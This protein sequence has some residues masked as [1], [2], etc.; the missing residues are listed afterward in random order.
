[1]LFKSSE[2]GY[3]IGPNEPG[4]P[5]GAE[6][7]ALYI[8]VGRSGVFTKQ[9]GRPGSTE[10]LAVASALERFGSKNSLSV[11]EVI[12]VI[13]R[14]SMDHRLQLRAQVG[15]AYIVR[16]IP[17]PVKGVV[18]VDADHRDVLLPHF[19]FAAEYLEDLSPCMARLVNSKAVCTCRSVRRSPFALEAGVDTMPA[20]RRQ[21]FGTA[22]VG[23][24]ASR[25][26]EMG[27]VP[28]YSAHRENMESISL[29]TRLK[30]LQF[31]VDVS[32]Y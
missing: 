30:M 3:L 5:D 19:P 10:F 1:L 17:D 9:S 25:V 15:P 6:V 32:L 7:P 11:A 2:A 18:E 29:A 16:D 21:G 22:T 23:A 24:W 14:A 8:C 13:R 20:N 31:A 27:L 12:E 26:W 4:E 28:C